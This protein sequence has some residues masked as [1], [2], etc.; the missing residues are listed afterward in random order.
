MSVEAFQTYWRTRH[1]AVVIK[2]PGIRRYVQSHTLRSAYREGEPV[3]D[4]IAEVWFD[5]TRVMR[6]G[7]HRGVRG[8]ASRRGA[9]HRALD[10][11]TDRHRGARRQGRAGPGRWREEG[12]VRDPEGRHAS[13]PLPAVLVPDPR[14]PRGADS[15]GPPLRAEPHST[16][17]LRGRAGAALRRRRR[18]VVR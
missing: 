10:H 11:G 2:L 4:G 9:V 16:L 7:L 18:H 3:Y 12:R 15:R 14:S 1:P 8:R 6:P 5:D 17:G 13:R